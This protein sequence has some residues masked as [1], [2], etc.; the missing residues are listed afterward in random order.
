[1]FV[2]AP[3]YVCWCI[4]P[5]KTIA[6]YKATERY[7]TRAPSCSCGLKALFLRE[8]LSS[9]NGYCYTDTDIDHQMKTIDFA[10]MASM[11]V[12]KNAFGSEGN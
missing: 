12:C 1:M 2:G 4:N 3:S 11:I 10:S 9:R 6:T 5:T 8:T 7:R